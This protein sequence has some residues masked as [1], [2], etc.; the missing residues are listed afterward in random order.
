[1]DKNNQGEIKKKIEEIEK[2]TNSASFKLLSSKHQEILK[3][4]CSK[5]DCLGYTLA[6]SVVDDF[7]DLNNEKRDSSVFVFDRKTANNKGGGAG[8]KKTGKQ[9]NPQAKQTTESSSDSYTF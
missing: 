7:G 3:K 5:K 1:M 8:N 6:T 9:N 4:C 2:F